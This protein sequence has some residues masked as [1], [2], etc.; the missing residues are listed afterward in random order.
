MTKSNKLSSGKD[1]SWFTKIIQTRQ[2]RRNKHVNFYL[3]FTSEL[4]KNRQRSKY[5][6]KPH[7][8]KDLRHTNLVRNMPNSNIWYPN[9][10]VP[11]IQGKLLKE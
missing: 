9:K 6:E 2:K 3:K 5:K 7:Q 11:I 1:R 4:K 8:Q 10:K